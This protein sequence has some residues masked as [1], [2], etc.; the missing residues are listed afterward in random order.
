MSCSSGQ[1]HETHNVRS[2]KAPLNQ[3]L[4]KEPNV[5]VPAEIKDDKQAR[6]QP[7]IADTQAEADALRTPPDPTIPT[8]ILSVMIHQINNREYQFSYTVHPAELYIVHS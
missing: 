1:W 8:G 5:H 6:E 4:K 2:T 3:A 7:S